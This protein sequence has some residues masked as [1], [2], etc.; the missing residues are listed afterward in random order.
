MGDGA[1]SYTQANL[2][3]IAA[4]L[5]ACGA[6]EGVAPGYLNELAPTANGANTVAVNTGGGLVDGKPYHNTASVDVNVPS[7]VGAGNTR[8]DRIVLRASWAAQTVRITRIAG[9]D[10][11]EPTAPALTQT[12]GTT[13]DISLCTVLVDT[14]GVVTATDART[15]AAVGTTGIATGAV[16]AAKLAVNS[17]GTTRIIDGEVTTAKLQN[18]SVTSAKIGA[19]AVIAGKL[20]DG[21]VDTAARLASDVV[22]TA[23]IKDLNVTE[24]KLAAAVAAKLVTSGNSHDHLGGD[25]AAIPA[26]GLADGSVDT[27]ARLANDVVDD[28]KVGNRVPA[29]TRRQGGS[30]TN[31]STPGTTAY[32][33]TAVRMQAG[34]CEAAG[35]QLVINFPVAFSAYPLVLITSNVPSF[36]GAVFGASESLATVT[37]L[38]AGVIITWLAIGPE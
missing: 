17:V 15:M 28:T 11:A 5:A 12:S 6:F 31:W 37:G 23:K 21:A 18:S 27:T 2:S 16:T 10:A 14:A 4:I 20:A 9:T 13:Y 34:R 8:I 26:G 19:N 33:P 24:G 3:T 29:L 1:V 25:G 38:E 22:E 30:A 35:A 36:P 32:T 7:A